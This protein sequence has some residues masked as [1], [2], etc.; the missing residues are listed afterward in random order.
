MIDDRGILENPMF[1]RDLELLIA[2][3]IISSYQDSIVR[4]QYTRKVHLECLSYNN[5]RAVTSNQI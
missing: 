3:V 5:R 2:I 1:T 4:K